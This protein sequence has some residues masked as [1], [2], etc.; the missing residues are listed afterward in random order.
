MIM[1]KPR[2]MRRNRK[3]KPFANNGESIF[4]IGHSAH[5]V[6]YPLDIEKDAR[7][8]AH[9]MFKLSKEMRTRHADLC[10]KQTHV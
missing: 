6:L 4:A 9:D 10:R 1:K 8:D 3:A 5:R 2:E 7:T